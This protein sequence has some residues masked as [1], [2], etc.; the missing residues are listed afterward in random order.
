MNE[1]V[2]APHPSGILFPDC[3][4]LVY[5]A[6]LLSLSP[7]PS[8]CAL[9]SHQ[10]GEKLE[11]QQGGAGKINE[12]LAVKLQGPELMEAIRKQVRFMCASVEKSV[13]S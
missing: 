8:L 3:L 2:L 6:L 4:A 10:E 13:F 5:L 12:A 9:L 1:Y 7:S 11:A